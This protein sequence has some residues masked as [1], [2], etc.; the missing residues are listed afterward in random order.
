M[1]VPHQSFFLIWGSFSRKKGLYCSRELIQPNTSD[2]DG[3]A[4]GDGGVSMG[5]Y[6]RFVLN[7]ETAGKSPRKKWWDFPGL[8][9]FETDDL[10]ENHR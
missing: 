7:V 10:Q 3:L 4:N 1:E 6:P 9:M 5:G 2:G 8:S